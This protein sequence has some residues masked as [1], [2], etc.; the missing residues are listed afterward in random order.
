MEK[1]KCS[2]VS[3]ALEFQKIQV[4]AGVGRASSNS[5][6]MLHCSI[7]FIARAP[8][9]EV[10]LLFQVMFEVLHIQMCSVLQVYKPTA[11]HYYF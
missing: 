5:H 8:P 4:I 1:G 10:S 3:S 9:L 2:K 11:K 7:K 6:T